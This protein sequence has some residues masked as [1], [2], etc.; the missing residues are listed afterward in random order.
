MNK[1]AVIATPVLCLTA[2]CGGS[3]TGTAQ[4]GA[5]AAANQSFSD[6]VSLSETYDGTFSNANPAD[7]RLSTSAEL[8]SGGT[9]WFDGVMVISPPRVAEP[10]ADDFLAMGGTS[11]AVDLDAGTAS[12]TTGQFYQIE[13]A[14]ATGLDTLDGTAIDGS[15]VYD[16]TNQSD[17]GNIFLG[18][19]TGQLTDED[20]GSVTIDVTLGGGIMGPNADGFRA[21]TLSDTATQVEVYALE[22]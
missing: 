8:P 6:L 18:D 17:S 22:R 20:G 1:V 21:G 12:G 14:T 9:A 10:S 11:I 15:V 2:A 5:V 13:T 16:L 7:N 19:A 4:F 3:S